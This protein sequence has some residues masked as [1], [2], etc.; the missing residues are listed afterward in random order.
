MSEPGERQRDVM[1][2]YELDAPPEK[3]WQA[4]TI[5]DLR[6]KWLPGAD[7]ADVEP[8]AFKAGE[9]IAFSMREDEPPFLES[10]VTFR[11]DANAGGGTTLKIWHVLTDQRVRQPPMAANGNT[12]CLMRAA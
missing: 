6:E 11:I 1:F 4:L 7:L 10:T 3:V 5:S 12:H 2:E 9:V 8:V